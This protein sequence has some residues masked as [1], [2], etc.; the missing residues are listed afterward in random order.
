MSRPTPFVDTD[1]RDIEG[2]VFAHMALA[3]GGD[4]MLMFTK[5][6][7]GKV[8]GTVKIPQIKPV[9]VAPRPRRLL[10]LED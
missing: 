6:E 9:Q 5:D 10:D 7:N 2:R 8:N 3:A 4:E 1:L